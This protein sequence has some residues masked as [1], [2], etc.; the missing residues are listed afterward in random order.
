MS[1]LTSAQIESLQEL[2][3][4]TTARIIQLEGWNRNCLACV[5]FNEAAETCQKWN[6]KPPARVILTACDAFQAEPF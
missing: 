5:H 4:A 6:M 2:L 3:K 1:N